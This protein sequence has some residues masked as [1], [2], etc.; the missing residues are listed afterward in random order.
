MRFAFL[1]K[2]ELWESFQTAGKPGDIEKQ[3]EKNPG[4]KK[5]KATSAAYRMRPEG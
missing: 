2:V 4:R 3:A 5:K 1:L